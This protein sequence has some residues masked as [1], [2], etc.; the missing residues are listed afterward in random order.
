MMPG[1]A[2]LNKAASEYAA[3]DP[4][5]PRRDDLLSEVVGGV[6]P[7][8]RKIAAGLL[9]GGVSIPTPVGIRTLRAYSS[10]AT[11]EDLVQEGAIALVK[12]LGRYDATKGAFS[13]FA[14]MTAAAAM[15][16][17]A[18][19]RYGG[20]VRNEE[21][22]TAYVAID[23]LV[24]DRMSYENRFLG[25]EDDRHAA[26]EKEQLAA[27]LLDKLSPEDR[28]LLKLRFGFYGRE[29]T[30]ESI[31]EIRGL[32]RER[33]RQLEAHALRRMRVHAMRMRLAKRYY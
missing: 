32:T 7:Y 25:K 12:G 10:S 3:L 4:H 24:K 18:R 13:T 26:M 17:A 30:L 19:E 2:R 33:I 20:I 11:I 16:H 9:N 23:D 5:D 22:P 1:W 14:L 8:L 6:Q 15:R 29:H 27:L 28:Q 21:M 31:G